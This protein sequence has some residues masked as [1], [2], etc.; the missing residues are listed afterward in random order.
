[1]IAASLA[2]V[3]CGLVH[4]F[5]TDR[6][7]EAVEP[8]LAAQKLDHLPLQIG[9]WQG[10]EIEV[11]PGQ[12][13]KGV[14]GCIQRRYVHRFTGVTVVLA[15]VCGRPGPVSIHTPEA[16]YDASGYTVGARRRAPVNGHEDSCDMWTADAVRSKQTEETRVRLYWGWSTGQGWSASEDPR[17]VFARS[18]VLHKLYVLRDLA[19]ASEAGRDEPCQAFL[20][21]LVPELQ[22]A[23]FA[24]GD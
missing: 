5:W 6:W 23:L 24:Q 21:A 16:C 22:K 4:G 17:L 10:E 15:M 1:M 20:Q 2:L 14:A 3:A 7:Q 9:D 19:N 13:G 18:P 12:V 8:S 11:G